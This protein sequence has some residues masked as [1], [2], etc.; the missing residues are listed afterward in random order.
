MGR[1]EDESGGG[2]V[3]LYFQLG[4]LGGGVWVGFN[5]AYRGYAI[6]R[7]GRSLR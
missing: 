3:S 6:I 5:G 7:G 2:V 4:V 1:S